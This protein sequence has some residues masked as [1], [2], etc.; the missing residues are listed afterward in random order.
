MLSRLHLNTKPMLTIRNLAPPVVLLFAAA[1]WLIRSYYPIPELHELTT[2][3]GPVTVREDTDWS[4]KGH[5]T[6]TILAIQNFAENRTEE[7]QIL[8]WYPSA[9]SLQSLLRRDHNATVWKDSMGYPWQI[10]QDGNCV[11]SHA[12]M[13]AVVK[14]QHRNAPYTVVIFSLVGLGVV[15]AMAFTTR[16]R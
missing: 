3:S 7:F 6:K 16:S 15:A 8:D 10:E 9:K 4:R 12:S 13:C 14:A 11:V 2:V 5:H 1:S